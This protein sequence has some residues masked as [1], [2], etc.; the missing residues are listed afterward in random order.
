MSDKDALQKFWDRADEV[1]ANANKQVKAS[2][3][4]INNVQLHA[5]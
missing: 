1:I 2:R 3:Q 5:H 4:I